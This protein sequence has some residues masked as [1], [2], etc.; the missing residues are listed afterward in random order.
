VRLLRQTR[1][2]P[3]KL[4]TVPRYFS[5]FSIRLDDAVTTPLPPPEPGGEFE[6]QAWA[7]SLR[8]TRHIGDFRNW[9]DHDAFKTAFERLL[10]DPKNSGK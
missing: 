9:K 1:Q 6:D 2:Q 3:R 4:K 8:R 5:A 10:R 7:A